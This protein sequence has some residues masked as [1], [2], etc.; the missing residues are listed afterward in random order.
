MITYPL[1]IPAALGESAANLKMRSTVGE[2]ISPF[3]GSAQQ[4][5]WQGSWWEL[6][7]QFPKMNWAQY[8]AYKAFLG[9]LRGKT[10]SFLW[11]PPWATGPQGSALTGGSPSCAGTDQ[12]GSFQLTTAG[13]FPTRSGLLLPGDYIQTGNSPILLQSVAPQTIGINTFTSFFSVAN[14]I[15]TANL[16]LGFTAAQLA[17]LIGKTVYFTGLSNAAN[18]WLNNLKLVVLTAYNANGIYAGTI[19]AAV[20][21][22]NYSLTNEQT[23]NFWQQPTN[24]LYQYVNSAPLDSDGGGNAVL[25]IFP[26]L[27]EAP[28]ANDPLVLVNPQGTFRLLEN[29]LESPA[30][31]NKTFSCSFKSREAI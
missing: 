4:Q 9:A 28:Q 2:A 27:H 31:S 29:L 8:S 11:G 25:D 1:S 24:R 12:P 22:A 23:G 19:T 3:T 6:D 26:A 18:L 10:G 15:L 5:P 14:G 21:H 13:W 20:D 17:A 7:L 16:P 30:E